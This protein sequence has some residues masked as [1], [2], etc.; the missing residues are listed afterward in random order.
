MPLNVRVSISGIQQVRRELDRIDA[1]I[2]DTAPFWRSVAIP[3]IKGKLRDIFSQEGP[4]WAPLTES[5]LRSREFP[6]LPILEQTGNLK[7][8]VLD[9]P[10]IQ[11]TQDELLYGTNNPYAPFHEHGTR[12][13]P[14]RPFL[15]PAIRELIARIQSEYI[16][17]IAREINRR[18]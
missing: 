13:M 15:Q 4:G 12:R 9:N 16:Q 2:A 14:A 11:I 10:I 6:G 8:S 5:T 1:R 18:V 3:I 17:Y 7:A